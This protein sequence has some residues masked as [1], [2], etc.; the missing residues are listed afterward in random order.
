MEEFG[1]ISVDHTFA[2]RAFGYKISSEIP[3]PEL[4][5]IKIENRLADITIK[6]ADLNDLW[7]EL[8]SDHNYF[9]V[10]E[11][12]VMF[13]IPKKAIFLIRNG[14][15]ICVDPITEL[16]DKHHRL[17]ILGTCMGAILMQ[18]K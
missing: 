16:Y 18:K 8:S 3:L 13:L 12:L 14:N 7:S 2:Y 11:N 17:Y 5:S 1:M 10:K 6:K 4:P 9:V 15:E